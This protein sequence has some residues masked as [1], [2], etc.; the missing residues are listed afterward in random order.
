MKL[1]DP[2][3]RALSLHVSGPLINPC[4]MRYL[5][6]SYGYLIFSDGEHCHLHDVY[7]GTK[8]KAPKLPSNGRSSIHYGIYCGLLVAPLT[9][10]NSHLTLL[11]KTSI[12]QWQVGANS[13]TEQPLVGEPILQIVFFK[14]QMFAMDFLQRLHTICIVPQLSIQ[15]VAVVWEEGMI[16]GLYSKPWLVV[17]GDM[18]LLVDLAVSRDL[19]FGFLGT[20][21]VFRL[22]FSYEPAK[23][24]KM[25]KLDN[26]ALFLANDRTP[27]SSCMNPERWGG[28]SN[29]IYVPMASEDSDEPWTAIEVGQPVPK[30]TH[31]MLFSYSSTVH[32]SRG[33]SL[34]LLP[35]LVY[36]GQQ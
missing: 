2:S 36:G 9:S 22:D 19:L 28:K 23:W 31:H 21:R 8:V 34:W 6:C 13:W 16:V 26:W 5:G 29:Y 25:E 18:L 20:F 14:G 35:S 33:N 27:T 12:F 15:E 7:T 11:S 24:V 3:K 4:L 32:S 17:C 10:P 30:T 1:V